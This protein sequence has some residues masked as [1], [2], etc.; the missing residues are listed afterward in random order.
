[1]MG[2]TE[3]GTGAGTRWER[4]EVELGAGRIAVR[5]A[6]TGEPLVFVHGFGVNGTLWD[7]VASRLAQDRRCILPDLPFGSHP[8]ALDPGADLSPTGAARLIGEL[9]GAL[10][11]DDVTLIAN[12]SGGA[13]SQI[14]LTERPPGAE[15]VSRLVLTNCDAFDQFPPG[16]F[17]LLV[18]TLRVPGGV[19]LI[20]AGLRTRALQR[21]PLAF[22]SLSRSRIPDSMLDAWTRPLRDRGIRRDARKFGAGMDSRYTLEA[23]SKLS[24]LEI[25]VLL[26]WGEQDRL[27]GIELAERLEKLIPS[28]RLVRFHEGLTFLP[29]DEPERLAEEIEAFLAST[30]AKTEAA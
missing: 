19:D 28:A 24:G 1:M 2:T 13:I 4:R 25:P 8:I 14:F 20:A 5:E 30:S 9:L 11:L 6:G 18:K 26:A 29:L 22:G 10:G 15:R 27:F 17:K 23:A 12:D 7:G 16:V 21:S 3:D